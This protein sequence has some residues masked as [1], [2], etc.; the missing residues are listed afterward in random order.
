[1]PNPNP[2]FE[3]NYYSFDHDFNATRQDHTREARLAENGKR[4]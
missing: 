1:M 4:Y 3:A 2:L